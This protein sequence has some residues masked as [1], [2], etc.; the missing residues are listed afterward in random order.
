[1]TTTKVTGYAF[2]QTPEGL[3]VAYTYSKIDG[4]GNVTTS[5]VRGSYIDSSPET[6]SFLDNLEKSIVKRIDGNL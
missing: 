6:Q 4:N 1:M 5:N 2:V 3:R